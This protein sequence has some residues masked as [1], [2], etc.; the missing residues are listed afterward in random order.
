MA[1]E[2]RQFESDFGFKSPGFTV[3]SNG[4]VVVTSLSY[5]GGSSS[6]AT[7][8]YTVTETSS[9][10]RLASDDFTVSATNNPTIELTR[11]TSYSFTLSGLSTITFNI[12]ASDGST[13]YNTGLAHTATDD[14]IT[15]GASAQGK[16]SGKIVFSV[17]ADAPATL[18][19][20]DAD[21]T[22]KAIITVVDPIVTGT[23]S[24][25][26][27]VVTGASSLQTLSINSTT[28]S[29]ELGTGGLIVQGGASIAKDVY[30]GGTLTSSSFKA[31][32]VGVAEFEAGTNIVLT[33]GNKIQV[34]VENVQR[35][36]IGT[37][38]STIPVVDTSIN[39]T[40]IGATT[41]STAAFTS[42]TVTKD[43][44]LQTDISNKKYVDSTATAL[45]IALGI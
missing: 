38:G 7:G 4:N 6:S 5:V 19:Y 34:V 41:A 3:D 22:P 13:L 27:L 14:T 31:N 42:A 2:Y 8:D 21:G 28:N 20:G 29:T 1:I 43:A 11:G 15:N 17:A 25:S 39:N 44:T 23:G 30:V 35:G 24:F 16:Q 10:F 12:L 33:A 26:D 45:S 18:Y 9:N 40:S 36:I 37:T 32:G